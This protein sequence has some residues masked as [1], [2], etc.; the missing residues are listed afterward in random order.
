[1][2]NGNGIADIY[3]MNAGFFGQLRQK[4][5]VELSTSAVGRYS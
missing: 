3:W 5:L 1:V 4:T 2:S